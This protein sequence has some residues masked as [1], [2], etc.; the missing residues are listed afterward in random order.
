[1]TATD[2]LADTLIG[3]MRRQTQPA[4]RARVEQ[5]LVTRGP[6]RAITSCQ[7]VQLSVDGVRM[8]VS[9]SWSH[10]FDALVLA[11]GESLQGRWVKADLLGGGLV[12][13]YLIMGA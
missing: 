9:T 8:P 3:L 1:M 5:V 11:Q 13:D 12:P 6:S 4:V 10:T 7:G 2:Q